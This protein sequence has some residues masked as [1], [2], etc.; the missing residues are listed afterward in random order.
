MNIIMMNEMYAGE[1]AEIAYINKENRGVKKL[2]DMGIRE[3]KL[4]DMQYCDHIV[5]KKVIIGI[6]NTRITFNSELTNCIKVRPLKTSKPLKILMGMLPICANC[7]Q[8]RDDNGRWIQI[9]EY[10][11]QHSE[12]DFSHGICQVCVGILYPFMRTNRA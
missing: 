3:G 2:Y 8:I 7:K 4:V 10:I 1:T 11:H 12:A 5:S 6:D 9:E